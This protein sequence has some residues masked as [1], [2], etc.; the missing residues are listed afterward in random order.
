MKKLLLSGILALTTVLASA[1]GDVGITVTS[2]S[3]GAN[4]TAGVPFNY[5]VT[6][7]NHGT[8]DISA[9]TDSIFYYFAIGGQLISG[10]YSIQDIPANGG[11]A[12]FSQSMT[13]T[14]GP[15]GPVDICGLALVVGPN[16]ASDADTTN[17]VNCVNVNWTNPSI[18]T[19]EFAMA[20]LVD[21]SFYSNGVYNVRLASANAYNSIQFEL[22]NLTGKVV[23]TY[24]ISNNNGEVSEDI[25][26]NS[27]TKGVYLARLTSNG[28]AISTRKIIV[29]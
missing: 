10:W 15:N 22:I 3:A 6:I 28:K 11:T 19:T 2:P 27:P 26:L 29:Q 20:Q 8:H 5:D 24:R 25:M 17:N 7:T 1:Q 12:M 16:W 14:G 18:G 13:V 23:Q 21:N 4:L 9:A